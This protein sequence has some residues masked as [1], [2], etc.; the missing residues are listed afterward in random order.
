MRGARGVGGGT[1][2]LGTHYAAG[3]SDTNYFLGTAGLGRGQLGTLRLVGYLLSIT[4]GT[5]MLAV[6]SDAGGGSRGWSIG[7]GLNGPTGSLNMAIAGLGS[8]RTPPFTFSAGDIGKVF[9]AHFT[10]TVGAGFARTY[11]AGEQIG[12]GTATSGAM[13]SAGGSDVLRIGRFYSNGFAN[14]NIGVI[15]LSASP[16]ELTAEQVAADAAAIMSR[17]SRLEFPSMPGQDMHFEAKDLVGSAD[18]HD[19]DG[20]NCTLTRQGSITLVEVT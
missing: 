5:R 2:E 17:S 8:L 1:R 9:V 4:A 12:S 20:D 3:W 14:P 16:T 19:R 13:V 10:V 7:T 15:A 18:W 6:R 11:I